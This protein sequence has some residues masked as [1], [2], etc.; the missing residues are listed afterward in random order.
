MC[1][2]QK[3]GVNLSEQVVYLNATCSTPKFAVL[4]R[5]SIG[6]LSVGSKRGITPGLEEKRCNN[7]ISF[8]AAWAIVELYRMHFNATWGGRRVLE[9]LLS[10][11]HFSTFENTPLPTTADTLNLTVL[12]FETS[13]GIISPSVKHHVSEV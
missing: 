2:V 6:I 1:P 4:P 9:L 5:N 11:M 13:R 3:E 8:R 7:L 10:V 12:D